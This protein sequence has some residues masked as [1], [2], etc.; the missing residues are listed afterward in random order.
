MQT[1]EGVQS[2]ILD[3]L[4]VTL[5]ALQWHS[6]EVTALPE[7]AKV[8]MTSPDCAVQAMSWGPRA[9]SA[10]FHVEIEAD[11]VENWAKIP[12]YHGALVKALGEDGA[13]KLKADCD[14]RMKIFAS[15]AE[16]LYINW[17][18]TTARV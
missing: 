4:P 11:T 6:A 7:G 14:A 9:F 5:D 3:G 15:N 13:A 17:L 8:L 12:E 16:R 10:Q 1:E 18:Q 2:V